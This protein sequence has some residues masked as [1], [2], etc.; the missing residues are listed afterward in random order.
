MILTSTRLNACGPQNGQIP[1]SQRT[2]KSGSV[3][4]SRTPVSVSESGNQSDPC[5]DCGGRPP[6]P[7]SRGCSPGQTDSTP[8]HE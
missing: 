5:F 4:G 8:Q 6:C 2:W 3:I 7:P 1:F